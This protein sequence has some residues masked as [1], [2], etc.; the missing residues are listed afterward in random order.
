MKLSSLF[1]FLIF[2][3]TLFAQDLYD[4]NT[5]TQ[6]E[7]SFYNENWDDSLTYYK[8]HDL[9]N[10]M[11]ADCVINGISFDSVGVK[12]KG[13]STFAPNRVKKPLNIKLNYIKNQ[14]YQGF[15]TLKMSNG[16]NEPSFVREVIGYEIARKYMDAPQCNYV[17]VYADGNYHGLY[18]S[19]ES[20][21]KKFLNEKFY[22]DKEN[23]F[24]KCDPSQPGQ[25]PLDGCAESFNS[26]FLYLGEDSLCYTQPYEMK[27][28]YGLEAL[29]LLT[30]EIE[31]NPETIE[32]HLDVDR[33]IWMMAY[34]NVLVN[35]DSY[36]GRPHHNYYIFKDDNQRWDLILWDVNECFGGFRNLASGPQG[37]L[38]NTQMQMLDPFQREISSQ[39]LLNLIFDNPTYKRMYMAHF[40]TI[41]E[42]NIQNDW[43]LDRGI[44]YQDLISTAYQDDEN[45]FYPYNIF[46]NNLYTTVPPGNKV[47]I[48]ELME[49]RKSFLENNVEVQK[50]PPT[51]SDIT[52]PD[53][54]I[55]ETEVAITAAINNPVNAYLMYRH[56][57]TQPFNQLRMYDDGTYGD[58]MANDGIWATKL[59][60]AH[61]TMQYY[62]YAENLEAGIFSP[63]RAA[64]EYYILP[65]V[66]DLVINELS[67]V[68]NT[69]EADQDGEYDDWIEL[70]NNS[71]EAISLTGYYLTDDI[72]EPTKWAFPN[73]ATIGAND[74]FM[75]WAD[76]D[77]EQEGIHA[78][79][80]L[81]SSGESLYLI[82][83][84]LNVVDEITF[85]EQTEDITF[86]RYPNGT[87]DFITME[88]PT[89]GTT[90]SP[91]LTAT[92]TIEPVEIFTIYPNPASTRIT[93]QFSNE[94]Q[95]QNVKIFDAMGKVVLSTMVSSRQSIDISYLNNGVYGVLVGDFGFQ[96]VVVLH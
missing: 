12:Y 86:G 54:A 31:N 37:N 3:S 15:Y 73:D 13:N 39:P 69:I 18:E 44:F 41:F 52:A 70:Y 10:R 22:S 9:D 32:E 23:P 20:V 27:S 7:L 38:S 36:L 79:F 63:V 82:D 8:Q 60:T 53:L 50:T 62:I 57:V 84:D 58:D 89:F 77:E 96:K 49:N 35:L 64:H 48:E 30:F 5:I 40:R 1:T 90:N 94:A 17:Q 19:A 93:I 43:Y 72:S 92:S 68:N 33:V 75:I 28:D 59:M 81:S 67:A 51:V 26:T 66:G 34:N 95:P 6:L 42:E 71:G 55:S 16:K 76:K 88:E 14:D 91:G 85:G 65:V 47:G 24:F 4:V 45:A 2:T 56:S 25:D 11:F 87:G 46:T 83:I 78:S 61:S 80:K 21:N 74:F 29:R